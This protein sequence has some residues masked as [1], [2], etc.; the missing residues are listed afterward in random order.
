MCDPEDT[1]DKL[2]DELQS[3]YH[4]DAHYGP[5]EAKAMTVCFPFFAWF[6]FPSPLN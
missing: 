5:I 4:L 3:I 6:I 1:M 2:I